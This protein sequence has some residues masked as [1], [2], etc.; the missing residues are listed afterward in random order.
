MVS[1]YGGPVPFLLTSGVLAVGYLASV[2]ADLSGLARVFGSLTFVVLAV[3]AWRR[4][5]RWV[6]A[7]GSVVLAVGMAMADD[8]WWILAGCVVVAAAVPREF[9]RP[10]LAVLAVVA[11]IALLF[12][13]ALWLPQWRA[14]RDVGQFL[15]VWIGPGA[16]A[17][18]PALVA[19]VL[20]V[21]AVRPGRRFIGRHGAPGLQAV[22]LA[23]GIVVL[24]VPVVVTSLP[25]EEPKLPLWTILGTAVRYESGPPPPLEHEVAAA[26]LIPPEVQVEPALAPEVALAVVVGVALVASA[27]RRK[28]IAP[29]QPE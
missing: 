11:P 6:L 26:V 14:A 4:D 24:A 17:Y 7:L 29:D 12:S 22:A 18:F 16:Q 2:S 25:E 9:R 1:R 5:R 10:T 21:L 27:S 19:V 28:A 15:D 3:W 23:F 20:A 13:A 8:R